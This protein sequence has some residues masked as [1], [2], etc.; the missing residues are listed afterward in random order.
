MLE[1]HTVGIHIISNS[2][3]LLRVSPEPT[4]GTGLAACVGIPGREFSGIVLRQTGLAAG[5][6]A[7]N[8]G[9]IK[10]HFLQEM[11]REL[12]ARRPRERL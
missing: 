4:D 11:E 12:N 6:G 8:L 5:H 2:K 1:L 3:P 9:P 7:F 10:D